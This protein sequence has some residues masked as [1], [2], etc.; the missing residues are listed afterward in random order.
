[1]SDYKMDYDEMS[2]ISGKR[3]VFVEWDEGLN[4]NFKLCMETGYHTYYNTWRTSNSEFI[5]SLEKSMSNAAKNS[6][7]VVYTSDGDKV[8]WYPFSTFNREAALYPELDKLNQL[9]WRI[10]KLK[11]ASN[12]DEVG[13]TVYKYPDFVNDT[14]VLILYIPA[15]DTPDYEFSAN[16]FEEAFE[17]FQTEYKDDSDE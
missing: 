7:V 6:K 1:M 11:R 2:P 3:T 4:D 10:S 8:I 5:T 14:P 13:D 15:S 16:E 12:V 9:K 17:I